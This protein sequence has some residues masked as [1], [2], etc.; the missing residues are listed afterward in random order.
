MIFKAKIEQV[1]TFCRRV[2]REGFYS[3]KGEDGIQFNVF[4]WNKALYP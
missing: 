4:D 1:L 3:K 2:N